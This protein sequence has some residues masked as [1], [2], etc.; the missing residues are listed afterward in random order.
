MTSLKKN[1]IYILLPFLF[2]CAQK[3][4]EPIS[5]KETEVTSTE[6]IVLGKSLYLENCVKCHRP[7]APSEFTEKE[8]R[9]EVPIMAKKAKIDVTKENLILS[10]VLK[11][12][13]K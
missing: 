2:S 9:H 12:A 6:D 11:E 5:I 13:K 10:Y 4:V 3:T 8:W 1:I 7:F